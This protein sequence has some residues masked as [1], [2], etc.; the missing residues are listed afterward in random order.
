MIDATGTL[1]EARDSLATPE[2]PLPRFRID[3]D[4]FGQHHLSFDDVARAR[5]CEA[6]HARVGAESEEQIPAMDKATGRMGVETRDATFGS[7][8][9]K[10][11]RDH[12][13]KAKTYINR[14]MPT[15]EAV[16]RCYLANDNQPMTLEQVRDYLLD[17]CPG[18]GCQ[19]LL[20][21]M[22]SLERL[23]RHD[24]FYGLTVVED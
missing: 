15:L 3:M 2:T 24:H 17:W 12:C 19:W 1:L 7:D 10:T 9:L 22:E 11:I 20:L 16:F 23:V 6:C 13:S 18:G 21:P 5:L 4:W 8:P 14:D